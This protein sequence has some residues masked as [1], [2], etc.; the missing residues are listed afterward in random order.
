MPKHT[1]RS[2]KDTRPKERADAADAE[3]GDG[4]SCRLSRGGR[5]VETPLS[6]TPALG[7]TR[8]GRWCLSARRG[9]SRELSQEGHSLPDGCP[10]PERQDDDPNKRYTRLTQIRPNAVTF[11]IHRRECP[12]RS[13]SPVRRQ[14]G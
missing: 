8:P 5:A 12:C 7:A 2:G 11:S 14:D 13:P 1:Q 4:L 9:L 6:L 10:E 3:R